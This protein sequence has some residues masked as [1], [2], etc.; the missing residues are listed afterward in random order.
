MRLPYS[1]RRVRGFS[2]VE[3]MVA[4]VVGMVA[5]I[6]A[7]RLLVTSEQQK[8]AAV[9]GS[10]T[11]QNGML[12]MFQINTDAAQAGWGIN[13]ALINGCNTQMQDT[14]GFQLAQATRNGVT[15]T[16]LAPVV[17][18]S[19]PN[20]SDVIT[21]Y[22]GSA[23]SGVGNVGIGAA[24]SGGTAVTINTN[25]PFNF[26][27]G[28]VLLV[29][30]E[31]AGGDCSL[32]QLAATPG[33]NVLSIVSGASFRY[34]AG[35]LLAGNYQQN[36]ARVFNLGR[37]EKLSFHTWSVNN[38]VLLLRATDLAGTARNAQTVINNV[39]AIKAQ[40]GFDTR[41]V[42]A[43]SSDPRP[44]INRWSATVIDADGDAVTGGAGDYQ[45]VSGIRLAVVARSSVPE[46]PNPASGTCTATSSP[47]TIFT[48]NA[49][50]GVA[51]VPA[52]V[53]LDVAGDPIDWTCYRYR[54][55]ETIVPIRNSGW[56]P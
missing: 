36:Q 32:A 40:Y 26:L 52:T 51:A 2:L 16:P 54:A 14:D 33:G 18:Q 53:S 47:L 48:G 42:A 20:R 15:V 31:P 37:P 8:S 29:A 5:V 55:F 7:T 41:T 22:S 28:D 1:I 12:A 56:R 45:R 49:P 23:L 11:M 13:D 30:P 3:L 4:V 35:S 24:Y 34:N 27:Q 39:I 43:I 38:G 25:A 6:F 50:N 9:G 44:Q 46:K 19:N 17:I 10:D 21:L